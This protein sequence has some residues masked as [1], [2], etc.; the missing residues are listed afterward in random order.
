MAT[1]CGRNHSASIRLFA[2]A[3]SIPTQNAM[4]DSTRN[5]FQKY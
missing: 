5:L 2:V 4:L 1:G 3:N